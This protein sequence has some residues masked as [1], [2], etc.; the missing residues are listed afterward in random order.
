MSTSFS[1]STDVDVVNMSRTEDARSEVLYNQ[2]TRETSF[3][4]KMKKKYSFSPSTT[5]CQYIRLLLSSRSQYGISMSKLA[6]GSTNNFMAN[7]LQTSTNESVFSAYDYLY[8]SNDNNNNNSSS[9]SNSNG[10]SLFGSPASGPQQLASILQE[11]FTK[12]SDNE[13]SSRN[14]SGSNIFGPSARYP[15]SFLSLEA[16]IPSAALPNTAHSYRFLSLISLWFV[17]I[18]NPIVVS[19]TAALH[20][21]CD[22]RSLL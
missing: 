5:L 6:A 4:F 19:S 13:S 2:P 11:L 16:F 8:D 21:L 1:M 22:H 15:P 17:L 3:S 7:L 18:V 9:G 14:P 10:F 20:A 12:M